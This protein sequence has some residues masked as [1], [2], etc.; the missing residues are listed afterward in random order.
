S[1]PRVPPARARRL[2]RGAL[3]SPTPSF[4]TA[5]FVLARADEET[6]P[7]GRP[8]GASGD[9]ERRARVRDGRRH[10]PHPLAAAP[11]VRELERPAGVV[12]PGPAD[13]R[14]AA[15][16]HALED[17]RAPPAP[18]AYLSPEDDPVAAPRDLRKR[19]AEGAVRRLDG[20][21]RGEE[22]ALPAA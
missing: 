11:R 10:E 4:R 7:A 3:Q 18:G 5:L 9:R 1:S 21:G 8:G 17:V 16:G 20:A 12:R 6:L 15:T 22:A 14:P 19:Q 2:R 13:R